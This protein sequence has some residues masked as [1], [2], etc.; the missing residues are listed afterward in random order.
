MSISSKLKILIFVECILIAIYKLSETL[1]W[2]HQ[3]FWTDWLFITPLLFGVFT[4]FYAFNIK[5]K[6]PECNAKQV[7][8][9]LSFFD[10]RWPSSKCYKCG[11]AL[12]SVVTR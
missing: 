10:I 7:F 11:K 5:C 12:D 9:G 3:Q 2:H 4:V 1:G 6:N 8:R